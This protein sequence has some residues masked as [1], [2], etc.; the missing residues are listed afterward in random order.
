LEVKCSSQKKYFQ[1]ASERP[2]NLS[3]YLLGGKKSNCN[4][5]FLNEKQVNLFKDGGAEN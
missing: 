3:E 1:E 2:K 4:F 5:I